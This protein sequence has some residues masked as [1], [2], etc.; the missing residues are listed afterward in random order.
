MEFKTNAQRSSIDKFDIVR[1]WEWLH[2]TKATN[3]DVSRTQ[4]WPKHPLA[5][6]NTRQQSG[7]LQMHHNIGLVILTWTYHPVSKLEKAEISSRSRLILLLSN[8]YDN[9]NKNIPKLNRDK[10]RQPDL[11]T[12]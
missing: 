7:I 4:L 6:I 10:I 9:N 3:T 8:V 2:Y 11:L 1:Q 12:L 5:K